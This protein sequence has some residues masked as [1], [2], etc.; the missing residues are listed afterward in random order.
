MCQPTFCLIL[1]FANSFYHVSS[2][3]SHMSRD[4]TM[5]CVSITVKYHY[6][7]FNLILMYVSLIQVTLK[8]RIWYGITKKVA[9]NK[10]KKVKKKLQKLRGLH[11]TH[12]I[13][14]INI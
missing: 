6:F 10:I 3:W 9:K 1:F 13:N 4:K 2:P 8:S 7:D 11:I 12:V 14:G 5:S